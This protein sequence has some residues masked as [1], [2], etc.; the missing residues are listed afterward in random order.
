[1]ATS[2]SFQQ[3]PRGSLTIVGSGFRSIIQFTTEA[4][5][6][7][8][9]AEKLYYCVLDAAT[10]GFIKAKNS[11]S[12]MLRSVRDGL[13]AT[14]VLYG[15]PGVFIHPSHRAIAIARSE[16]YDAW[17]LLGISVEDYLFADLLIDPSNPGTQTVEAT[18]ILLKE[19]PLLTSSHVI[20]YQVGCIGNFTFNFSG[21][22]N[23]K[24]DALVDR[25]IQEYGPDHPLVNYQAA[26]SPLSEASIGRHIVSDLRKA[27][28]QESV[29]G[30]ST[31]YIPPKTV[32]QV[33]P[34]GAKL[35]SESD[36]LPTYL[37]K[38]V[39]VF[40][41]FP[42]NQ[43]L[44]PIAPAYSS[45]ERKAIEELDNHITPLEYRKYNASSAM[46]K[47]VESIS[48]SLDTIKKFRES[49]SAF[50]SSI[51]ELEPHE[52]DALSTGS[53]ERIDAAM[54]GNAAVNPNAAWLITF[55]IIFGK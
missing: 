19:R 7:I 27:E 41:P 38:D 31:F 52:I 4:L 25:L 3:L 10:R 16:G 45:A 43:S 47:T 51:E 40:P 39:P 13:K 53:G 49:P 30:A 12:L 42:F 46:Q 15:H 44:A 50:A 22:K 8:E 5:M 35:V 33:T 34:Q 11:N 21:I 28:V 14:V 54:Q 48:F 29:T 2:S 36:E 18:E 17:M 55:A 24:F 23:D 26:I 20:I 1:M 6:H 37:S 9:A 32:L